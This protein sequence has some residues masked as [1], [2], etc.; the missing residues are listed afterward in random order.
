MLTDKFGWCEKQKWKKILCLLWSNG[1]YN[2]ALSLCAYTLAYNAGRRTGRRTRKTKQ[3]TI[4]KWSLF[5]Q[6]N[7]VKHMWVHVFQTITARNILIVFF[8]DTLRY[9]VVAMIWRIMSTPEVQIAKERKIVFQ[10]SYFY[11]IFKI[12]FYH[13]NF[14]NV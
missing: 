8:N 6:I 10:K 2:V 3:I 14:W 11:S 4:I 1:L 12:I 13:C 9:S 5:W 7:I